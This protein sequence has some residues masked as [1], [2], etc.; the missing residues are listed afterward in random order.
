MG[1]IPIGVE[2]AT[3]SHCWGKI[4][5]T[6]RLVLTSEN[7]SSWTRGMPDLKSMKTF[8]QAIIICQKLGL[9]YIWIDSLCIIQNS[10]DDWRHEASLMSMVYRYSNCTITATA[11]N[12]D[13]VGCFF[14]RDP[15]ICL[16]IRVQF[17][18]NR[19]G[20][21][22]ASQQS[23]PNSNL[24]P[25]TSRSTALQGYYDIHNKSQWARDIIIAPVNLRSWV[26]QERLLSPRVLHF[27]GRQLYWECTELQASESSPFGLH[28]YE[29]ANF[30]TLSPYQ[31]QDKYLTDLNSEPETPSQ[32]RQRLTRG[33]LIWRSVLPAYTRGKLSKGSDRL[34]AISAIARELQPLMRCRYLAGL[35]EINLIS[36]LA[37]HRDRGDSVLPSM[38]YRAP[39]W[40][41]ASVDGH[42]MLASTY[43]YTSDDPL[44]EILEAVIDLVSEDEFGQV[45]GGYLNLLGQTIDLEVLDKEEK[46]RLQKVLFNGESNF[47]TIVIDTHTAKTSTNQL[48]CLPL[49]LYFPS[50]ILK[51]EGLILECVDVTKNEY[52]RVGLLDYTKI[53]PIETGHTGKVSI[54]DPFLST[55]GDVEQTEYGSLVFKKGSAGFREITIL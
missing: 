22:S 11:A 10:Q 6:Q 29:Q 28:E 44:V 26:V 32:E 47:A 13:T 41:W 24:L 16:P 8:D 37:W 9:E 46:F 54:E 53:I 45:Q 31:H 18:R 7:V 39:S 40:S 48:C 49:R 1:D 14:N 42:I 5:D 23:I 34:I 2:Y 33:F 3:L 52:R 12:D 19:L 17:P 51:I 30:K 55:L 15:D 35:W 4:P 20:F 36:Q 43:D 27:S 25:E 50:S 21:P 38:V